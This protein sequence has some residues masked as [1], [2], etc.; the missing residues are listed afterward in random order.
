MTGSPENSVQNMIN[1]C[2]INA[3]VWIPRLGVDVFVILSTVT[4]PMSLSY[5]I[6]KRR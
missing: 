1:T 4:I 3:C 5:L 6:E 2:Y